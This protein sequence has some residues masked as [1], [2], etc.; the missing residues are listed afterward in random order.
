[1]AKVW[2]TQESNHDFLAA[3]QFGEV[4]FIT[5]DD[6]NNTRGSLHNKALVQVL[7][8]QLSK[9]IAHEDF[10]V[11]AGS[12]YVAAAVFAI[13]G[14]MGVRKLRIL[15]WLNRDR[16]YVPLEIEI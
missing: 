13:L 15:R 12:P 2:V 16:V 14:Q 6:L 8:S 10:L 4:V 7:R 11:I 5:R 9:F 1:M 3:E